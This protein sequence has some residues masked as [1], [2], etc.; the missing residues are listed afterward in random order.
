MNGIFRRKERKSFRPLRRDDLA[1]R[2]FQA[3]G[4]YKTF[5]DESLHFGAERQGSRQEAAS[6][7]GVGVEY[8]V[9][10]LVSGKPQNDP[11]I[12]MGYTPR[13]IRTGDLCKYFI[14]VSESR[15]EAE[16]SLPR[17]RKR[18]PDA[19]LVEIRGESVTRVR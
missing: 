11:S 14:A 4:E 16:S 18:Y 17:I 9:Q 13:I 2:L 1:E 15:E 6:G 5:Y 3:F 8:A 12:F 10:I 7:E 19:F